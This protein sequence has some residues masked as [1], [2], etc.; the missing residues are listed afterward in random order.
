MYTLG[1]LQYASSQILI[2][3]DSALTKK[4]LQN[5]ILKTSFLFAVHVNRVQS[6]RQL[7]SFSPSLSP[8]SPHHFNCK[9]YI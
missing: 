5:N 9:I 3:K 1:R 4:M 7:I 8:I 6:S 2:I